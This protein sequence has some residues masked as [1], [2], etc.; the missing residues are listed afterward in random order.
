MK[1]LLVTG[2]GNGLGAG[3]ATAAAAAGYRVGILDNDL[4]AAETL[5][6]SLPSAVALQA[7]VCDADQVALAVGRFA[8][9]GGLDVLVNNAGILRTGPLIDHSVADFRLVMDVNLNAVFVVAQAAARVMRDAGGGVIVN[10]ASI[11]GI[12][13]SPNCG[14]YAAAK[15]GVL[16]LTQHMSLEWGQFGI[17]VNAIAPGFIDAGMSTP[18]YQDPTVRNRRST[19]VPLNRL[20]TSEDIANAVMFLASEQAGYISGQTLTVDGGVVNSV[21]LQLPRD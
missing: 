15:G 3:I 11:N 18:F 2:G 7:D 20:G 9:Q 5:A 6:A 1:S 8:A 12:H 13:P 14:A 19:A 16:A 17:R 10:L 21:L 4:A